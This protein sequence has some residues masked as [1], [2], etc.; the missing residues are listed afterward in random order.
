LQFRTAGGTVDLVNSGKLSAEDALRIAYSLSATG[1]HQ[2]ASPG[3]ADLPPN[4]IRV[5]KDA[6]GYGVKWAFYSL[7]PWCSLAA[8]GSFTLGKIKDKDRLAREAEKAGEKKQAE[9]NND[10]EAVKADADAVGDAAQKTES[11]EAG[12]STSTGTGTDANAN[13]NAAKPKKQV[14]YGPRYRGPFMY[15]VYGIELLMGTRQ[16]RPKNDATTTTPK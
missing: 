14:G 7:L 12:P 11:G 15:L 6:Y 2:S 10:D 13:A 5:V 1:G 8:I 16:R 4:L 3:I 9:E